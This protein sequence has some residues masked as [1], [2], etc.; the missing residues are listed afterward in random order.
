MAVFHFNP[1]AHT[2]TIGGRAV[3]S[4]TAVLADII[5]GWLASDW[6]LQRGT[7]VHACA[8]LIAHGIKFNHD[9]HIDG[10]VKAIRAFFA[11]VRPTPIMVEQQ[12]Y[13]VKYQYAGTLDM[14]AEVDGEIRLADFK[15][16]LSP[17]VP[18]QLAAYALAY[19][20]TFG[21]EIRRG[22]GVEIRDN[23]TYRFSD[24]YDLRQY[25]REWLCLLTAY[26]VRRKCGVKEKQE[27][28]K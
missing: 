15:A 27:D 24:L 16:S 20:E 28:E 19:H 25:G 12:V 23:G 3:P 7:A 17:A 22:F 26:N 8:A 21:K 1:A 9:P 11:G 2:Y 5:P 14:V 4:V 18:Y 6:Y 10:Q 13:S